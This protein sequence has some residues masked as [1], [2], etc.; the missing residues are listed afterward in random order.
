M[1][2]L[3]YKI[4]FTFK[5]SYF[6]LL[7]FSRGKCVVTI[8]HLLSYIGAAMG[9]YS[10]MVLIISLWYFF[11]NKN[12]AWISPVSVFI[13]LAIYF[14]PYLNV[15]IF[16]LASTS[17]L[18]PLLDLFYKVILILGI[19]IVFHLVNLLLSINTNYASSRLG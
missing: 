15:L 19:F 9:G 6:V 4:V 14:F 11:F 13:K 3:I 5:N 17:L 7:R 1:N 18:L 2:L 12:I 8:F 16:H 10:N